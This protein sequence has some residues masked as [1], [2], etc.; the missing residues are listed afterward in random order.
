MIHVWKE[1]FGCHM[2]VL[3]EEKLRV[4]GREGIN[5]DFCTGH[6]EIEVPLCP[7]SRGLGWDLDLI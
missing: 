4:H 2:N 5:D 1:D 3:L 6:F 7:P